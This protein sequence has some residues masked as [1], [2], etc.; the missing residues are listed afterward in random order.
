MEGYAAILASLRASAT[1]ATAVQGARG[2]FAGS[3]NIRKLERDREGIRLMIG[4]SRRGVSVREQALYLQAT[5]VAPCV[6]I[7][8]QTFCQQERFPTIAG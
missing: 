7:Q 4:L 6:G 3:S 8:G 2:N 5:V 1:R